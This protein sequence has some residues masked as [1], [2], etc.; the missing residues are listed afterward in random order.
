[1]NHIY[2]H[3]LNFTIVIRHHGGNEFNSVLDILVG[4]LIEK[5]AYQNVGDALHT[6]LRSLFSKDDA[7]H[8]SKLELIDEWGVEG[9]EHS[10]NNMLTEQVLK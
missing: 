4:Q 5:H 6:I 1:M 3:N 7:L 2:K 9:P 10:S 8:K